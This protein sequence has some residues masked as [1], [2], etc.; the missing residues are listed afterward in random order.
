MP[1]WNG[2]PHEELWKMLDNIKSV[3]FVFI[4]CISILICTI[5][6][7][8]FLEK[9]STLRLQNIPLVLSV[10]ILHLVSFMPFPLYVILM[11]VLRPS[12]DLK[13]RNST[14][15]QLY[16]AAV[17]VNYLN[18]MSNPVLYYFTSASFKEYIG[19]WRRMLWNRMRGRRDERVGS[20]LELRTMTRSGS[21]IISSNKVTPLA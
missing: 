1:S 6:M 4:P 5:W 17:Y 12:R 11:N 8:T 3:V 20:A 7:L 19:R 21:S 15:A 13:Y 14:V 9:V 2:S 16:A 18:T 10:A